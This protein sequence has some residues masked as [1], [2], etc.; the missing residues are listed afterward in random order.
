MLCSRCKK[1]QA[2]VFITGMINGEPA[3]NTGL[4]LTCAREMG[5]PQVE[6]IMKQMG[7]DDD[8]VENMENHLAEI[9]ESGALGF[10]FPLGG[11]MDDDMDDEDEEDFLENIQEEIIG[12][13]S[14]GVQD[15]DD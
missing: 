14:G 7:L 8:D 10:P 1:R 2:V 4:C 9:A 12:I 13:L 3:Q 6:S 5:I 15:D 11:D